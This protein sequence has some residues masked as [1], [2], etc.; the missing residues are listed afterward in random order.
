MA[1]SIIQNVSHLSD[2]LRNIIYELRPVML[3]DCG[4]VSSIKNL[5]YEFSSEHPDI[6]VTEEMSIPEDFKMH[7][8]ENIAISIFRITQE[9]LNNISKHA[10]AK[11]VSVTLQQLGNQIVLQVED[12]GKGFVVR[13]IHGGKREGR[14][15]I[16]LLGV[17]ERTR[18]MKGSFSL[19]TEPGKG[20]LTKVELPIVTPEGGQ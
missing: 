5:I 7:N 6:Q 19:Q 9:L 10:N 4:L 2:D 15:G 11:N 16:G 14:L 20:T 8:A 17:N 13:R 3:E 1:T 18:E 12:D